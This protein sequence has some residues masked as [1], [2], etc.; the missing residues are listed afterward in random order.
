[1]LIVWMMNELL[2][3]CWR[4]SC[5]CQHARTRAN[6]NLN[7]PA[8]VLHL[9][10]IFLTPPQTSL[11]ISASIF[12]YCHNAHTLFMQPAYVCVLSQLVCMLAAAIPASLW[13]S[14]RDR[15]VYAERGRGRARGWARAKR[16][17]GDRDRE[18]DGERSR[19]ATG[20][21]EKAE[22][23]ITKGWERWRKC[24]IDV[25]SSQP[26]RLYSVSLPLP[27]VLQLHSLRGRGSLETLWPGR[28]LK[29]PVMFCSEVLFRAKRRNLSGCP[30][31]Y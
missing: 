14:R 27:S 26:A 17:R 25:F 15:G 19:D 24:S 4:M 16:M 3:V 28:D 9:P 8:E 18:I 30:I 22:E 31:N 1:M 29:N 23:K 11:T 21:N 12:P 2:N 10:F 13:K 20:W 5:W 6:P 7:S